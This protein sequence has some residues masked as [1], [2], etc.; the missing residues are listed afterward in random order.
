MLND[1]ALAHE[2]AKSYDK[3]RGALTLSPP[4][5][6]EEKTPNFDF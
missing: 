3:H 6:E 2:E 1:L 5:Q 4:S